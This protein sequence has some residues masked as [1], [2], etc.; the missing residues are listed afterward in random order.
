MIKVLTTAFLIGHLMCA[1]ADTTII[2]TVAAAQHLWNPRLMQD[3]YANIY[4]RLFHDFLPERISLLRHKKPNAAR[5][6]HSNIKHIY[7]LKINPVQEKIS[8][9]HDQTPSCWNFVAIED[10]KSYAATLNSSHRI[11]N[12]RDGITHLKR[13]RSFLLR[14]I[15]ILPRFPLVQFSIMLNGVFRAKNLYIEVTLKYQINQNFMFEIIKTQL[16]MN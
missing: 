1:Q 7:H 13:P 4:E 8:K 3:L 16:I 12:S 2:F 9:K 15:Q 10:E 11:R 6:G 14:S 5:H